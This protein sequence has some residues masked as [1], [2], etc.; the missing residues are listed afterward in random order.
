MKK[1][2][3]LFSVSFLMLVLSSCLKDTSCTPKTAASEK[4]TMLNYAS[5]NGITPTEHSS[6]LM[7]E[8][9]AQGAGQTAT[10]TS[11]VTVRYTGKLL[12][13]TIFDSVTGTPISFPLGQVI[14]GWQLGIPLIQEGGTIKLIIPSSL[15]YGCSAVGSIP[16]NSV[17][18][19]EVQLVDVQ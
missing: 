13:G 8:V 16:A 9:I 11:T 7:Y 17:L 2:I 12:N 1:L 15:A 18:F 4:T 3:F 10:L 6:G 5:A 14:A 19:F